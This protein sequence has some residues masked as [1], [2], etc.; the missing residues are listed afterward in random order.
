MRLFELRGVDVL[1]KRDDGR[2]QRTAECEGVPLFVE[3]R[4]ASPVVRRV[5]DTP[6]RPLLILG[7]VLVARGHN[8][9]I[10]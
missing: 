4:A 5:R 9:V 8:L 6:F 10:V 1:G 2:R 3:K 7:R